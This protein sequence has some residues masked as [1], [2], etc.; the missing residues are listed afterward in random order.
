MDLKDFI[1]ET[2]NQIIEGVKT[3]QAD[4]RNQTAHV[5]P[6]LRGDAKEIMK[7]GLLEGFYTT[8][9][10]QLVQFDVA[11]TTKEG[12]GAK[13]GIGVFTGIISAGTT[14]QTNTENASVSRVKFIVPL[15]LP[16]DLS[17]ITQT[18]PKK[19]HTSNV[20]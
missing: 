20:K 19:G 5:N 1:S 4:A 17:G 10:V 3:A 12:T 7:H 13:A 11:L 9:N 14:G 8:T 15:S 18:P 2:L 16:L 6:P